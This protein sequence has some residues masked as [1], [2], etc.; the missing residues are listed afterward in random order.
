[1]KK[2]FLIVFILS[3]I[4]CQDFTRKKIVGYWVVDDILIKKSKFAIM[5]NTM[6][7]KKDESCILPQPVHGYRFKSQVFGKWYLFRQNGEQLLEIDTDFIPYN[8]VY[9]IRLYDSLSISR[10]T[11]IND[12]NLFQ[13]SKMEVHWGRLG[14]V[15]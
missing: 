3:L 13:C 10:M 9:K 6:T 14:G 1:M 7:F 5:L 4:S 2:T 11:L 8:G 12:S 15:D